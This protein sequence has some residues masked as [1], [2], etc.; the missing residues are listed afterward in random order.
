MDWKNFTI[1]LA[2]NQKPTS[3]YHS[4]RDP[5]PYSLSIL[6]SELADV[7]KIPDKL[8]CHDAQLYNCFRRESKLHFNEFFFS[9]ARAKVHSVSF[10]SLRFKKLVKLMCLKT[11]IRIA[12]PTFVAR[13]QF[14][15]KL[16]LK[17]RKRGINF[18]IFFVRLTLY[19][20]ASI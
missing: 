14:H 20:N 11:S 9:C 17:V 2:T 6:S 16:V 5:N 1:S 19:Q 7:T 4:I 13:A 8:T 12:F 15:F 10:L 18:T 3:V